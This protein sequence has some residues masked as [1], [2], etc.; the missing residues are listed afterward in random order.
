MQMR[1]QVIMRS[2]N[3]FISCLYRSSKEPVVLD[4]GIIESLIAIMEFL[5][6]EHEISGMYGSRNLF[7]ILFLIFVFCFCSLH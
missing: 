2:L 6:S 4:M 3:C 5:L 1:P 7:P